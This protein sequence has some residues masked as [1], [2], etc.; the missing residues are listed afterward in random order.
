MLSKYACGIVVSQPPSPQGGASC[1][2]SAPASSWFPS[3]PTAPLGTMWRVGCG[4]FRP[5]RLKC[6]RSHHGDPSVPRRGHRG[7]A[8]RMA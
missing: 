4:Q 1:S 8:L 6:T 3:R 7:V 2:L 5:R